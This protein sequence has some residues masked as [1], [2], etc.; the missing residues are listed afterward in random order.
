[1]SSEVQGRDRMLPRTDD[2]A[3]WVTARACSSWA[4]TISTDGNTMPSSL[5]HSRQS[6]T[7]RRECLFTSSCI[8]IF[9]WM[10]CSIGLSFFFLLIQNWEPGEKFTTTKIH[11]LMVWWK[12]DRA[13]GPFSRR[14]KTNWPWLK[15]TNFFIRI[16][17][18]SYGEIDH[19]AVVARL[20]SI[21][22]WESIP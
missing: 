4:K 22:E 1:M 15:T 9:E 16:R 14:H 5:Y 7:Y 2:A 10:V 19:A 6:I 20:P 13:S 18:A 12:S 17:N 11:C 3:I 21:Q 8:C